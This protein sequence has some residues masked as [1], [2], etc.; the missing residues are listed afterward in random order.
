MGDCCSTTRT[1]HQ[2]G[3]ASTFEQLA[4]ESIKNHQYEQALTN[5][6]KALESYQ[7]DWGDRNMTVAS[8]YMRMAE[9]Y[10]SLNKD[11]EA[12]SNYRKYLEICASVNGE[13]HPGVESMCEIISNMYILDDNKKD[14]CEFLERLLKIKIYT[15]GELHTE[16]ASVHNQLGEIYLDLGEYS[17]AISQ[18]EKCIIV[19]K[20]VM[21]EGNE[22]VAALYRT[23]GYILLAKMKDPAGAVSYIENAL[24]IFKLLNGSLDSD[25]ARCY[26][27]LGEAKMK[28]GRL[29]EARECFKSSL[30]L[31]DKIYWEDDDM[32]QTFKKKL[33][34]LC[35][36][37][38]QK[39]GSLEDSYEFEKLVLDIDFEKANANY[40]KE[41]YVIAY[42]HLKYGDHYVK[43]GNYS[44]SLFHY[45][46]ALDVFE[47]FAGDEAEIGLTHVKM[48][49]A[50]F[51]LDRFDEALRHFD[52]AKNNFLELSEDL[53]IDEIAEIDIYS[54]KIKASKGE[55]DAQDI[56]DEAYKIYVKKYGSYHPKSVACIM[57]MAILHKN[58][59]DFD[60]ALV[61]LKRAYANRVAKEFSNKYQEADVD[62]IEILV[63]GEKVDA[64]KYG[65]LAENYP[66]IC[67]NE[68]I[69]EKMREDFLGEDALKPRKEDIVNEIRKIFDEQ[70]RSSTEFG[71]YIS[72]LK[73]KKVENDGYSTVN[74][75]N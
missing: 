33:Y 21:G 40:S 43:M 74:I 13:F 36:C 24:A 12:I 61:Y 39:L 64:S 46:T 17:N 49:I 38:F 30:E 50:Y 14:A 57:E 41:S 11:Q 59:K 4:K 16:V 26:S 10:Q 20:Y 27:Q 28:T 70:G 9:I 75:R 73:D 71:E 32:K 52:E 48:G 63:E 47:M 1:V 2:K 37:N 55:S 62:G 58:A 25:V 53:E 56:L 35:C 5:Y 29:I 69:S 51:Y 23:I 66:E 44:Q 54:A 31:I 42:Y 60:S 18:F 72:K 15:K 45:Q 67:Q 68:L 6:E 22:Q 3:D 65:K 8:V 19:K 34:M 7:T